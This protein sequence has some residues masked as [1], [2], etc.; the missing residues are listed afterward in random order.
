MEKG[1][2]VSKDHC[3]FADNLNIKI[4][5]KLEKK[6]LILII[7]IVDKEKNNS[8]RLKIKKAKTSLLNSFRCFRSKVR[9]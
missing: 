4:W 2:G 5:R 1:G 6:I 7:L 9:T 8:H 3:L